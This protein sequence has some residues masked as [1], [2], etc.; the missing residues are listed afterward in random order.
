[1]SN[2]IAFMLMPIAFMLMPLCICAH[3]VAHAAAHV[4]V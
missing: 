1:M 4:A 3:T 2:L